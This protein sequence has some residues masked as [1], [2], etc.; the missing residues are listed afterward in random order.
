MSRKSNKK[1]ATIIALLLIPSLFFSGSLLWSIDA[2]QSE[3]VLLERFRLEPIPSGG[4]SSLSMVVARD[5]NAITP[6]AKLCNEFLD[7]HNLFMDYFAT[8]FYV[9]YFKKATLAGTSDNERIAAFAALINNN[10]PIFA[11]LLHMFRLF[12][13][14]REHTLT[15]KKTPL[16]AV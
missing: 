1:T 15:G 16:K 3:E 13:E 6:L 2:T 8:Q 14:S 9:L 4:K 12:L 5:K 7:E 11:P 10:R